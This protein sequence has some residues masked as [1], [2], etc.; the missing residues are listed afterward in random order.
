MQNYKYASFVQLQTSLIRAH[1]LARL[2]IYTHANYDRLVTH[3][4]RIA[5]SLLVQLV[6]CHTTQQQSH[7]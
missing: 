1:E 7:A 2:Q 3:E 4:L 6:T 5:I